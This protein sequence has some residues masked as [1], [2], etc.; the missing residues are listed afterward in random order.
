MALPTHFLKYP[1][2]GLLVLLCTLPPLG[3]AWGQLRAPGRHWAGLTSYSMSVE[4]DSIFAYHDTSI[5]TARLRAQHSTGEQSRFEWLRYDPHNNAFELVHTDEAQQQSMLDGLSEGGYRVR[6]T[7]LSDS[8]EVYTAW[9]FA[10]NVRIDTLEVENECDFMRISPRTRP[11]RW[12]VDY[13]RFVYYDL[14]RPRPLPNNTFGRSYFAQAE[15]ECSSSDVELANPGKLDLM[16]I[17]APLHNAFYTVRIS[18]PFGRTLTKQTPELTAVAVKAEHTVRIMQNGLWTDHSEGGQYEALLEL[19]LQSSSTNADLE[20]WRIQVQQPP[21]NAY[22]TIW[23]DSI[24]AGQGELLPD[25][26]MMLP[27]RYRLTHIAQNT[28]S[29]CKDSVTL[30]IKVD[31]SIIKEDAIPNVFTPTN[32]DGQNDVFRFV[33][34]EQNIRSMQS[35]LIRIYNRSGKLMHSYNGDPRA[36]DGWDGKTHGRM[37]QTGV[38]YYII[39]CR[40]WDGQLFKGEKFTGFVYLY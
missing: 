23:R 38:Y 16:V 3:H 31:S 27:G 2:T 14:S 11:N 7:S 40:G 5:D 33:N 39:E 15:W 1:L 32:A 25:K 37:A 13:D 36:W 6:I 22:R 20:H 34:P 9:L 4:Q 19:A 17:P 26:S 24:G 30:E 10:D 18:T 28:L 21:R 12:D 35:C 29:G 8:V